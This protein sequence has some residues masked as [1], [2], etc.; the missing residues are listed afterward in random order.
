LKNKNKINVELGEF[1]IAEDDSILEAIGVGSCVVITFYDRII[2]VGAMGH[3]MLPKFER[4]EDGE[5]DIFVDSIIDTMIAELLK[6]GAQKK[7]IEAK[8]IGGASM[9]KIFDSDGRGIG[10]QNVAAAKEKL[11]SEGI[12]VVAEATGGSCGRSVK[13]DIES[14]IVEVKIKV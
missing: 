1:K 14:G 2:K 12:T 9:F 10:K 6:K 13:F 8:V 4:R 5:K 7:R 3:P 11:L